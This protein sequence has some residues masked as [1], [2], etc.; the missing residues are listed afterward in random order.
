[1]YAFIRHIHQADLFI[2][3]ICN[4]QCSIRQIQLLIFIFWTCKQFHELINYSLSFLHRHNTAVSFNYIDIAFITRKRQ[5]YSWHYIFFYLR[6]QFSCP[7]K[8]YICHNGHRNWSNM[9]I[10]LKIQT[11]SVKVRYFSTGNV[12]YAKWSDKK[13]KDNTDL[14]FILYICVSVCA[15]G[16]YP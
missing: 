1:M 12:L 16:G 2:Q 5:M 15:G 11:Y 6:V 4:N 13:S 7:Q 3:C 8:M 10:H 9:Y 14:G